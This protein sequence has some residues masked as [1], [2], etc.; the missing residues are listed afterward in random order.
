MVFHIP[1]SHNNAL[2]TE[3]EII[4]VE[5]GVA[6]QSNPDLKYHM[7]SFGLP[8]SRTIGTSLAKQIHR[9]RI[10]QAG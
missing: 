1:K 4:A 2:E 10:L 7:F 3:Q 5:S 9:I 8:S 6:E